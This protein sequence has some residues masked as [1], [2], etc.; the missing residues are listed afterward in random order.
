[1]T[2]PFLP[3]GMS[4]DEMRLS[5]LASRFRSNRQEAAR[6]DIAQ[7]YAETV[8]RLIYSG[9]WEL[10]PAPE[11]QLPDDCMPKAFFA[12]WFDEQE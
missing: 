7:D 10:V 4:E 8:D 6:R 11:D 2:M 9:A 12:Y 5:Q 3:P 1:M